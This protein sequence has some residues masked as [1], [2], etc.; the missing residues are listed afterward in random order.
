LNKKANRLQTG[1]GNQISTCFK[2]GDGFSVGRFCT[3]KN[4]VIIGDNV[5]IGDYCKVMH[6]AR[7]G[8]N[9]VIMDYVKLM[10]G[11]VI[12]HN[13]KLDDYVNTSGYCRIGN[14]VRIK[15]MSVIAQGCVIEDDV[16]I[17]VDVSTIRIK[18]PG[19]EERPVV[20]GRGCFIGTKACIHAGVRIG[21]HAIIGAGANVLKDCEPYGIY[22]G[23]PAKFIRYQK[24]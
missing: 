5:T 24:G 8:N 6:G 2:H 4:D 10:P 13:C 17:M 12:G 15:R 19:E 1:N 20:F 7:I 23:N 18:R 16:Q 22:V 3:I 9:V 21:H 11:T 14:N